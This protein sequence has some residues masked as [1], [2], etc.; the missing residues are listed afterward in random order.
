M[1]H[2]RFV[3]RLPPRLSESRSR[4]R[5]RPIQLAIRLLIPEGSLLLDLQE[6]RSLVQ[7]YDARALAYPWRN[8]DPA[9]DRLCASIQEQI[10]QQERGRASRAQIFRVI[11][12]LAGNAALPDETPRPDRATIPYLTE[13]WYC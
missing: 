5:G 8:S 2:W 1:D 3:P 13:P 6:I 11:W 10:K 4:R 9:L 7:P 12:E